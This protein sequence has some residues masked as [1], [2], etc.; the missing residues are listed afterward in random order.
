M[1]WKRSGRNLKW[2]SGWGFAQHLSK[3]I[4]LKNEN[5]YKLE[6]NIWVIFFYKKCIL[7]FCLWKVSETKF[8]P[9]GHNLQRGSGW[10][11][12]EHLTKN[13][14]SKIENV[15]KLEKIKYLWSNI[16]QKVF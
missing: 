2:G 15:H 4:H 3:N 7:M 6:I 12:A 5:A 1:K 11:F 14:N 8:N 9:S 16:L 10:V 13:Y